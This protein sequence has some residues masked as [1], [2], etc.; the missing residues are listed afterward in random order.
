MYRNRRRLVEH[1]DMSVLINNLQPTVSRRFL[2]HPRM[3]DNAIPFIKD[4]PWLGLF[5]I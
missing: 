2:T 3:S 5:P 1:P 4:T